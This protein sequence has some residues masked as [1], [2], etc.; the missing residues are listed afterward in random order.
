VRAT[1][2]VCTVGK[3]TRDVDSIS[4]MLKKGMDIARLNMNY[5]GV[6]E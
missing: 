5:F 1:K 3:E 6:Q 2:I 4:K